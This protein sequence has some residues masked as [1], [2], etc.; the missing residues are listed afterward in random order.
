F[1]D[2][3]CPRQGCGFFRAEVGASVPYPR[4]IRFAIGHARCGP[5]YPGITI[6]YGQKC[7]VT[8][9]TKVNRPLQP[10]IGAQSLSGFNQKTLLPLTIESESNGGN[11]KFIRSGRQI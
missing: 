9:G 10:N 2:L 5:G 1:L 7:V 3:R 11:R 6:S 4:E 8:Y